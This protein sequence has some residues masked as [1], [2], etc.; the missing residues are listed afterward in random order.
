VATFSGTS[1]DDI[2]FVSARSSLDELLGLEGDDYLD[3]TTGSGKN[4]LRGG[5]GNDEL[6]AYASDQLFG[7][8]GS[9]EL[10][11]DGNGANT[12]YGGDA[13]D[14]IFA[15]RDD[16]VFGDAGDDLIFGGF[17]ANKLTGG[18]GKDIFSITPNGV[19]DIP[20]EILDFAKDDD[21]IQVTAI[22]EVQ[23]FADLTRVQVGSDTVLRASVGGT[24][25]DLGILKNIQA[26]TL[27]PIVANRAPV[28]DPDKT[29]TLLE[30]AAPTSL[31]I[32]APT[33]LD[34]DPLTI[35]VES[36]PDSTKGEV[37]LSNG[38]AVA[39]GTRLTLEQ[40]AALVFVPSANANGSAGAFRYRVEDGR[41]GAAAQTVTINI[42][43][44]ENGGSFGDPHIFSFDGFHYDFQATGDFFLVKA[45]DSDLQVQVRQTPWVYNPAATINTGLAT[46]VDGNRVEFYYNQPLPL[47][48][49]LP[50]FL[51]VGQ[52][53][54]LGQGSISRRSIAGYGLQGDLYTVTYPTGDMLSNAVFGGF[55]MDPTLDLANSR[56]V[57][58]L[59]GNNNGNPNDDLALRD[60]TVLT[61]PLAPENLYG[62]FANSWQVT[63][64]ESLFSYAFG[65]EPENLLPQNS[66]LA[67]LAQR[68][69]F[70]GNGDDILIGVH[71]DSIL[72]N[73]GINEVD[74]FLGNKGADTFVLGDRNGQ[75]Y[76][77]L[78]LQDYALITDF[79]AEDKI[80][81]HGNASDYVLGIAP[82]ELA[83]GTG[84]FLS[85]DPK[86]LIGI[87]QGNMAANLSLTNPESFVY[88]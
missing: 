65:A 83:N 12:L 19:P 15:D 32:M 3:A 66:D 9:D 2:L 33:D 62:E 75:F 67:A 31:G 88:V 57:G 48:N 25:R 4:T 54:A 74:L 59:L 29:I 73:P 63:D 39:N 60:G 10:Y 35:L 22:P 43:P 41:G 37:R 28:A 61:N 70:G 51:E 47:I 77:N 8:A 71:Q 69:I 45:E 1:K 5:D 55:L 23:S 20:N 46:E 38:S 85:A 53:Q 26:E 58:G 36:I 87:I 81:L 30:D 11:S 56:N 13:N 82:A 79:W 76:S 50:L 16:V 34:G 52:S 6:Y 44:D 80:Q 84:I 42:T 72:A 14:T 24:V 78:G 21:T 17:G 7:D 86:E 27:A 49:N 64:Q 18:L 40:L 68:Y